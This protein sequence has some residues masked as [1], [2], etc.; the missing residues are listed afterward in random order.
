[1]HTYNFAFELQRRLKRVGV[2]AISVAAHPGFSHTSLQSKKVR[3]SKH[4]Y[5]EQVAARL[6][7]ESVEMTGVD[8]AALRALTQEKVSLICQVFSCQFV[9]ITP[10]FIT[11]L[12]ETAS[13]I[14]STGPLFV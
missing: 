14:D 2:E 5:D 3:A 11:I 9:R 12:L 7:D 4:A 6:W 10:V 1:V 8:Y 13:E